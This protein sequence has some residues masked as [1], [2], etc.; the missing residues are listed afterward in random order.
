MQFR[1][2]L[3]REARSTATREASVV[4][5]MERSEIRGRKCSHQRFPDFASLHPGLYG[6]MV[7]KR[8]DRS[9]HAFSLVVGIEREVLVMVLS[10]RWLAVAP[11]RSRGQGWP[12]ATAGGGA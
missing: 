6:D 12:Q 9:G 8:R 10:S 11:G 3:M 2:S 4:A 5:R 7:V 1:A